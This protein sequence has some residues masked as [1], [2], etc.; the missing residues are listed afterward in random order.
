MNKCRA[1]ALQIPIWM[2]KVSCIFLALKLFKKVFTEPTIFCY[3][4][5]FQFYFSSVEKV[6]LF[7]FW[8][9][10]FRHKPFFTKFYQKMIATTWENLLKIWHYRVLEWDWFPVVYIFSTFALLFVLMFTSTFRITLLFWKKRINFESHFCIYKFLV[11]E[12]HI[13]GFLFDITF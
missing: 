12:F 11:R 13:T 8:S 10:H 5:F 4:T 1:V 3:F 7:T 2:T 6:L 9:L